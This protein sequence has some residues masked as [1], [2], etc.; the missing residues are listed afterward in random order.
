MAVQRR[1]RA[2][3]LLAI[4][5]SAVLVLGA[6]A[7]ASGSKAPIKVMVAGTWTLPGGGSLAPVRDSIL[8]GIK[9]INAAGG[10]DGHQMIPV[11]CDDQ[12]QAN[13]DASCGEKAVTDHVVVSLAFS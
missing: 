10:V 8:A 7:K 4:A 11:V 5:C 1:G 9:S 13:L 12:N 2:A 3:G 6:C